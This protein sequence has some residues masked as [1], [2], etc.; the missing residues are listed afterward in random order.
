MPARNLAADAEQGR[1]GIRRFSTQPKRQR[2]V[3]RDGADMTANLRLGQVRRGQTD[4]G[5]LTGLGVRADRDL[6]AAVIDARGGKRPVEGITALC[7]RLAAIPRL[8]LDASEQALVDDEVAADM[9]HAACA[10]GGDHRSEIFPA[11]IRIGAAEH[12]QIA[13]DT[14]IAGGLGAQQTRHEAVLRSPVTQCAGRGIEFA[15]RGGNQARRRVALSE[16]AAGLQ[17][18]GQRGNASAICFDRAE[19][20]PI[21]WLLRR[22]AGEACQHQTDSGR[23]RD[24]SVAHE[25]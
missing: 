16:G 18:D 10:Q 25:S 5:F 21:G 14:A 11:E 20:W 3:G 23:E 13:V 12:H 24:R 8:A 19:F 6:E 7:A 15:E 1:S 17:V 9:R 2:A 22:R 4:R